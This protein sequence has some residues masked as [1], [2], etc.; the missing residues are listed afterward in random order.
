MLACQKSPVAA[1]A[2][3]VEYAAAE[4]QR[5]TRASDAA[6]YDTS[7][8]A[9]SVLARSL[10]AAAPRACE[11]LGV[12]R[13]NAIEQPRDLVSFVLGTW[14]CASPLKIATS[15]ARRL[16][17][18]YREDCAT[19]AETWINTELLD[20]PLLF[21]F[22]Q[23][24]ADATRSRRLAPRFWLALAHAVFVDENTANLIVAEL[25]QHAFNSELRSGTAALRTLL[26][27]TRAL[28]AAS[29]ERARALGEEWAVVLALLY[30][31]VPLAREA[32]TEPVLGVGDRGPRA[33]PVPALPPASAPS[34]T[35]Y[36]FTQTQPARAQV[37][38]PALA[39][40]LAAHVVKIVD[41][42]Q[43]NVAPQPAGTRW[44][45]DAAPASGE[46]D[47]LDMA[48]P[49]PARE[50][51]PEPAPAPAP[52]PAPAVLEMTNQP[53]RVARGTRKFV[54]DDE[55]VEQR[56]AP[57]PDAVVREVCALRP[58][59]SDAQV[60]AL[61]ATPEL[62]G[63]AEQLGL[64]DHDV[65]AIAKLYLLALYSDDFDGHYR[66]V[67]PRRL[68]TR[69]HEMKTYARARGIAPATRD[70]LLS[71]YEGV[72]RL[73]A[74]ARAALEEF[75]DMLVAT[76]SPDERE[77]LRRAGD[78]E[79]LKRYV[80]FYDQRPDAGWTAT[81]GDVP[82]AATRAFERFRRAHPEMQREVRDL[83][84]HLAP[85]ESAAVGA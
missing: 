27:E 18:L 33:R 50:P 8:A 81:Y 16:V 29:P 13:G 32:I 69:A 46:T 10:G 85:D 44:S 36:A 82:P 70:A 83:I 22:V 66:R 1:F 25:A 49:E 41:E 75:G 67:M 68:H 77:A 3:H 5:I 20:A 48:V 9:V 54:F 26:A 15:G 7:S 74:Q 21:E 59:P 76:L 11:L 63:F 19:P 31:T 62:R 57:L 35:R 30:F 6:P 71:L 58:A 52:T 51:E 37:R 23:R 73:P 45:A 38:S 55:R 34:E 56:G 47:D 78:G 40:A 43:K 72:N 28:V 2:K 24:A 79:L 39:D 64:S 42:T 14:E 60:R 12:Q 65:L 53:E 80:V 17:V 84:V 4:I 61:A